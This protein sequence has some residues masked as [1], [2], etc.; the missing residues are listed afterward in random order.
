MLKF[1]ILIDNRPSCRPAI[2]STLQS[3]LQSELQSE[4]GLSIFIEYNGTRILCDT[5]ASSAFIENAAALGINLQQ[6]DLCVISHGHSDHTGG[7][8]TLLEHLKQPEHSEHPEHSE[9]LDYGNSPKVYLS[10]QIKG[11]KY[12][13][14]RRGLPRDI[15]TDS[16]VFAKHSNLLHTVSGS[17][18]I[19]P[20]IALV[21]CSCNSHP[22]PQG[23]K[24]LGAVSLE[25]ENCAQKRCA[26]ENAI[27]QEQ[28][29]FTHLISYDKFGHELALAIN[30]PQGVAI[31]SPC[32]HNGLFNIIESAMEFTGAS[33]L[34]AFIGG[35]HL[36]DGCETHQEITQ[37]ASTFIKKY[38]DA[39]LFT[40]HCTGDM[41]TEIFSS[42]FSHDALVSNTFQIFHTGYEY[43]F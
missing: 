5:G 25:H 15:S 34:L 32:S 7:L 13:S 17:R 12:Y 23:N 33:K 19:T 21:K 37:M 36:V 35:L 28:N 6:T 2:Q 39:Q 41:A 14:T 9:P 10:G 24:F 31:F 20:E 30:T 38:P 16:Q 26:Q 22:Q 40:G 3:T 43:I 27:N 8:L 4:H 42:I 29:A 18:W 1:R 11:E